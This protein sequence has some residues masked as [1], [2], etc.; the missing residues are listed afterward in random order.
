MEATPKNLNE[1]AVFKDM[2]FLEEVDEIHELHIWSITK[3]K[4]SL[5]THIR[6]SQPE[7]AVKKI[8]KMLREKYEIY[9]TT[10]HTERNK[11]KKKDNGFCDNENESKVHDEQDPLIP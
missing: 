9:H 4:I 3:G 11:P 8:N 1:I 2:L 10:I 6:S 7:K 5:S